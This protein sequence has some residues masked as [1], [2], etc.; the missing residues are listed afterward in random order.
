MCVNN[1]PKIAL[2]STVAGIESIICNGKS[3][4]HTKALILA[5]NSDSRVR[6]EYNNLP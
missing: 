5:I 6:S 3:P 1:L 2:D 4:R